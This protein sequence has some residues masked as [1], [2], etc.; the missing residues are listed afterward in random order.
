MARLRYIDDD[1]VFRTIRLADSKFVF[2]RGDTCDHV[3]AHDLV[4]REHTRVDRDADGR[5]RIRDLGSRNKTYVNGQQISETLLSQGDVVRIGPRIFEYLEE[6]GAFGGVDLSFLTPDRQDPPETE[7]IKIKTP[8]TLPLAE[9]GELGALGLDAGHP[10]RAEDVALAAL[11]RLLLLFG[12]DRGFVGLRGETKKE[13]RLVA[14]R[15]LDGGPGSVRTPVSQTFVYSAQLQSVAG[16]Y[17]MKKGKIDARAG[18]ATA[19]MVAPL[20]YRG[21][22]V[23]VVYLDR[24]T[25]GQVFSE[26]AMQQLAVA[27]AHVGTLMG[28][29]SARLVSMEATIAPAWLSTLRRLQIS[30]TVPPTSSRTFEIGV[31]LIAGNS[32][33][34]DF[35][36]VI[37]I[38]EDRTVLVVVDAGG[39]GVSGFIHASGVRSAIRT[40][41]TVDGSPCDIASIMSAVNQTIA[42]QSSRQL[43]A[44]TVI[45]IDPSAGAVRY[46]NA[47]GPPP[48]VLVG[49]G[50]MVTL[51]QP[52][53]L[54]GIDANYGYETTSVDLP[55]V[56]RVIAH[57]D[58]LQEM[59]NAGGEAIGNQKIH[60]LLLEREAFGGCSEILSR[61]VD[62]C[63]RHRGNVLPDDD[64]LIVVASHG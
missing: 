23:G 15:G 33:C 8:V 16:R 1:C 27:G 11:G 56:F 6:D 58:G 46:V 51:D 22:I 36:D 10:A 35:C 40:A 12:A 55:G 7:W 9:W 14:H 37:H 45:D 3:I 25:S 20:V 2:G 17:P 59:A 54:L 5:Y 49:P 18:M 21:D 57:T 50:R 38:G 39:Q 61:V 19:A 42:G 13:I 47:G 34:G 28:E 48:M 26:T 32:R 24:P 31:K 43:V 52:S 64:A 29:A 63:E 30:M 62:A 60:D 44:C 53:L 41:L 4:S